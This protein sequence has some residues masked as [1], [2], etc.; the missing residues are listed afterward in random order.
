MRRTV[1]RDAI[2]QAL[3][4]S[5]E[6]FAFAVK[7]TPRSPACEDLVVSLS[8]Q[9]AG[10]LRLGFVRGL[11]D[12]VCEDPLHMRR[13]ALDHLQ[14]NEGE[15]HRGGGGDGQREDQRQP[16]RG[17]PPN[18]IDCSPHRAQIRIGGEFG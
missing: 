13:V 6:Q 9:A 11:R 15:N 3:Q 8:D 7:K 4:I 17:R 5:R 10:Q 18:I 12:F 1:Y 16:K 2:G 14:I